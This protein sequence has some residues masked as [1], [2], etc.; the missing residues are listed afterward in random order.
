MP[1]TLTS[2]LKLSRQEACRFLVRYHG[3]DRYRF[4]GLEGILCFIKQVGC[5]QYDPLNVV[6]RNPDLVLQARIPRYH[7]GLLE[8]LLYTT[9]S[10][11]DGWDKKM[12]IYLTHD[13]PYLNHLRQYRAAG[14]EQVLANRN[15]TAAIQKTTEVRRHLEQR[16][17]L[18]ASQIKLGAAGKGRW[19][20]RNLAGAALDLMFHHGEVGIRNRKNT[21]KIYDFIENLLPREILAVPDP[22]TDDHEFYKWLLLRR[23]GSC[24]LLRR[25]TDR[26][27]LGY[28]LADKTFR[29]ELLHEL[30]SEKTII[31]V[32]V[33]GVDELFFIR[34]TDS[35]LLESTPVKVKPVMRFL[36]PLDNLLWDR[37]LVKQLFDFQYSWEVYLPV[38]K[39]KYG[40]YVLPVLYGS[41]LV[42]RFE[43]EQ[44]KDHQPLQIKNWW[45]ED[46]IT[47]SRTMQNAA[48][49]CLQKFATYLRAD[50]FDPKQIKL[51]TG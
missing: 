50:G 35:Q 39:R 28:R 34:T 15:S 22:F 23:I 47:V 9:R 12:S 1:Q 30:Q 16:G 49:H 48:I 37:T 31:P 46:S 33:Q 42:A 26:S 4:T 32:M 41:R 45:W 29:M 24:G 17:P 36:A 2:P 43:P 14:M 20:H 7:P 6:G 44:H 25:H 13:W 11:V 5:I 21:Q 3:L 51:H 8:N 40:Y 38:H 27:I 10:L 18:Q 19:G